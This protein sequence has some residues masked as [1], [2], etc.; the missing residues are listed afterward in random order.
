MLLLCLCMHYCAHC[1]VALPQSRR[2]GF[3]VIT[4]VIATYPFLYLGRAECTSVAF[5]FPSTP[6]VACA[7]RSHA[8]LLC[9]S[10]C[11]RRVRFRFHY[12]A[13]FVHCSFEL[14]LHV[15]DRHSVDHSL[16]SC[17][18]L[19][20][21]HSFTELCTFMHLYTS[22]IV[23][24]DY[25]HT[26]FIISFLVHSTFRAYCCSASPALHTVF[27]FVL[28]VLWTFVLFSFN[29]FHDCTFRAPHRSA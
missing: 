26:H 15:L 3:F 7:I 9:H 4:T 29:W 24:S 27:S 18:R 19:V 2:C 6:S 17:D 10:T 5:A 13:H 25:R 22:S 1:R 28:T 20:V 8:H 21:N 23:W 16:W 12:V 11:D 14:T